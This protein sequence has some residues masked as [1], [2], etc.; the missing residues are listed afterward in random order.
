MEDNYNIDEQLKRLMEGLEA[1]PDIRSFDAVIRKLEKKKKRRGLIVFLLAGVAVLSGSL[2]FLFIANSSAGSVQPI[3]ASVPALSNTASASAKQARANASPSP[4]AAALRQE[5]TAGQ[6]IAERTI[7]PV[8]SEAETKKPEGRKESSSLPYGETAPGMTTSAKGTPEPGLAGKPAGADATAQTP[9][10]DV[11][12]PAIK[13]GV[14]VTGLDSAIAT[15]VLLSMIPTVLSADTVPSLRAAAV[16]PPLQQPGTKKK[17]NLYLGM[18][19]VPQYSSYVFFKNKKRNPEYEQNGPLFSELYLKGRWK[20]EKPRANYAFGIKLNLV[21]DDVY[22][23]SFGFGLQS[24]KYAEK[25]YNYTSSQGNTGVSNIGYGK[26]DPLVPITNQDNGFANRFS[27][28]YYSLEAG[29]KLTLTRWSKCYP[30]LGLRVEQLRYAEYTFAQSED[31]YYYSIARTGESGS[32]AQAIY[33][34][35]FKM[36]FVQDLGRRFR[37]KLSPAVFYSMSSM[38]K[39]DYVIKQKPYGAEVEVS[40]LFRLF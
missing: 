36:G 29:R 24:Y 13:K 32:L 27:Y 5:K 1:Q 16:D 11:P 19:L 31:V 21:V 14:A 39:R 10:P 34:A 23:L 20:Q 7:Q 8:T 17:I 6:T 40:L 12:A 4:G 2:A 26:P 22:D 35:R 15:P 18:D 3:S 30:A 33:T 25:L 9:V 38:F 37:L 28:L